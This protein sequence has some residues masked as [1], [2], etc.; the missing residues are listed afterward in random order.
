MT[1]APQPQDTRAAQVPPEVTALAESTLDELDPPAWGASP[2][3]ASALVRRAHA[4]RKVPLAQLGV[5]GLRL[6]ISQDV[7]R[8]TL[9][10][11]A[12]GM[13]RH[14]PLAEGDYYPGDLLQ[15]VMRVPDLYWRANPDQ[16]EA[17]RE[18]LSRLDRDDPSYPTFDDGEFERSVARFRS[19]T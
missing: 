16:L 15:A 12:L 1:E 3:D 19:D 14:Q 8:A 2:D 6:L 9:V 11:V 17:L 5:E 4:L 10:P 13:L 7:A 18:A